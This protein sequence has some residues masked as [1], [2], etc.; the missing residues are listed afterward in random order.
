MDGPLKRQPFEIGE[1]LALPERLEHAVVRDVKDRGQMGLVNSLPCDVDEFGIKF[2]DR[3]R[4]VWGT[5]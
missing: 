4:R 1:H 2:R 3:R 5:P